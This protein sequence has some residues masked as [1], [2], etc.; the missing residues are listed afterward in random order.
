M[1]GHKCGNICEMCKIQEK[2]LFNGGGLEELSNSPPS[3]LSSQKSKK[4]IMNK[5]LEGAQSVH[6]RQVNF[7]PFI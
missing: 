6:I 3:L 4:I 2:L 7:T 5:E 1:L